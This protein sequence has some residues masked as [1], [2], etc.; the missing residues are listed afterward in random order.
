MSVKQ[1]LCALTDIML[2][3]MCAI[4]IFVI[5]FIYTISL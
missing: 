3:E 1:V 4:L 2:I 5:T